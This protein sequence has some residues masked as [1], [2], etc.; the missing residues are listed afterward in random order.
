[1]QKNDLLR[2]IVA[3]DVAGRFMMTANEVEAAARAGTKIKSQADLNAFIENTSDERKSALGAE[4]GIADSE[5]TQPSPRG[6]DSW[7]DAADDSPLY[8]R[9]GIYLEGGAG[10][11]EN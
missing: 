4:L 2:Y 11:Y 3:S 8:R 6:Y 7:S 10:D 9:Q 5:C 1:M